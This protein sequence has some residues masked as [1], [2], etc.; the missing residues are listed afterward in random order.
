MSTLPALLK[1]TDGGF[2]YKSVAERLPKIVD[3]I[4]ADNASFAEEL[5]VNVAGVAGQSHVRS[6]SCHH[7]YPSAAP[8]RCRGRGRVPP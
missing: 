1:G 3:S 8:P 6:T 7:R 4:I 5:K 2:T